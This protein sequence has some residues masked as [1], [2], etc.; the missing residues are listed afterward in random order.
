MK[1]VL[2]NAIYLQERLVIIKHL[3]LSI[4]VLFCLSH[5]FFAI[6]SI[7]VLCINVTNKGVENVYE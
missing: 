7:S 6:F 4:T 5:C 2:D 3:L 1:D